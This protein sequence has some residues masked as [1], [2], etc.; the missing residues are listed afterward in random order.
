MILAWRPWPFLL[1]FTTKVKEEYHLLNDFDFDFDF[2]AGESFENWR[3][4]FRFQTNNQL[5]WKGPDHQQLLRKKDLYFFLNKLTV[6]LFFLFF[7][8]FFFSGKLLRHPSN[9]SYHEHYGWDWSRY[10][11]KKEVWIGCNIRN[12]NSHAHISLIS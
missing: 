9:L 2:M 10:F 8:T 3:C 11:W 5:F 6:F 7:A 1:N 12:L 4:G